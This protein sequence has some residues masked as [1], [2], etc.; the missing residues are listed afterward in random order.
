MTVHAVIPDTQVKPGLDFFTF[1]MVRR[2]PSREEA[3]CNRNDRG[4]GGYA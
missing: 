2:V 4:L 3:G 1:N